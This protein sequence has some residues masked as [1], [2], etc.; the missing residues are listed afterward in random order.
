MR[1]FVSSRTHSRAC[2]VACQA[3]LSFSMYGPSVNLSFFN[4]SNRSLISF[5]VL[6]FIISLCYMQI[7]YLL[8]CWLTSFL[9]LFLL[10]SLLFGYCLGVLNGESKIYEIQSGFPNYIIERKT[11]LS[12]KIVFR[13]QDEC[14]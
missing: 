8:F 5:S 2:F 10:E 12:I 13:L 4:D 3:I 14:E 9:E 6:T 1:L 11:W 7:V